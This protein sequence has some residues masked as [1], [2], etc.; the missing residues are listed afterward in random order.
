MA[1][2]RP[3]TLSPNVATKRISV[4]ATANQTAFTPAGGYRVNEIAVYRNGSR[5]VDG[6]DFTAT[7][8]VTVTLLS[9]ATI[10]DIIEF[11]IFD[12]YNVADAISSNGDSTLNGN[13]TIT[14]FCS[15][16]TLY[17]DGSNITGIGVTSTTVTD[18]L[19]VIG[20]STQVGMSTFKSD[21]YIAGITTVGTALSLADD[22]EARF[23]NAGDLR[24]YHDGSNSYIHDGG[25]GDL[26]IQGASDV[27]IENTAGANSAVFNTDGSVELYYR[28]ASAGK[29]LETTT[30]GVIITGVTT[31]T[32]NVLVGSAITMYASSGIVSAT[33]FYGDGSNLEGVSASGGGDIDITS[34]LFI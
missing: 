4:A 6:H 2:G 14:G 22:V 11:Q 31:S 21:V 30:S 33:A 19:Y 25:T 27:I 23:G 5:L 1:I 16:A 12:S 17:G 29:K 24:I 26:K 8:G 13:L 34:C 28:G 7:D 15:A 9:A 10:D 18:R 3:I 32:S 20:L